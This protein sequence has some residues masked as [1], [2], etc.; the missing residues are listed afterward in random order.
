MVK[1]ARG[2]ADAITIRKTTYTEIGTCSLLALKL[3]P[4]A[5]KEPREP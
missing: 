1:K 3:I 4:N 5:T 2:K